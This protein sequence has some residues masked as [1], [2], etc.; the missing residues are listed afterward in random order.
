[1]NSL[2]TVLLSF[3]IAESKPFRIMDSPNPLTLIAETD[4]GVLPGAEFQVLL[5]DREP[6]VLATI[7]QSLMDAGSEHRLQ[8]TCAK[9]LADAS[10][11]LQSDHCFD[12]VLVALSDQ[13]SASSARQI[14]DALAVSSVAVPM[15]VLYADHQAQLSSE[16]VQLGAVGRVSIA[17]L[18][19]DTLSLAITC[20]QERNR[21]RIELNSLNAQLRQSGSELQGAQRMLMQMEKLNSIGELA[22]GV[23]HEVKNPLATLQMGVDY[24]HRQSERNTE[25]DTGMIECMQEAIARASTI[26]RGMVDFS[27]CDKL[28]MKLGNVN[29]GLRRALQMVRHEVLKYNVKVIRECRDPLPAVRLDEGKIEQ[30]LINVL[31]NAMQAMSACEHQP[32]RM[33][34]VSTT[35]GRLESLTDGKLQERQG[36]PK[37]GDDVVMIE[38]RDFGPGIPEAKLDRVFDP[39]FTT[40]PQGQGT[41]LG[42]AVAKNIID[43]HHGHLQISNETEP[44]GLRVRIILSA[45]QL[46]AESA[47][48]SMLKVGV[49]NSGIRKVAC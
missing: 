19:G 41:G 8:M 43:L 12:L 9:S 29:R 1:M 24:F 47:A 27:R 46:D 18:N 23:A 35:S 32:E 44:K 48:E 31:T 34:K 14:I 5:A 49:A 17:A 26:I 38:I 3:S 39:F 2:V 11:R 22:A 25:T 21:S 10:E 15:I 37:S 13:E 28:E 7:E 20:I 45:C 36:F 40:K 6:S 30:V 42:M 16:L 33:L 4:E